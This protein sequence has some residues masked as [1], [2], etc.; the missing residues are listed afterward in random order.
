MPGQVWFYYNSNATKDLEKKKELG[1]CTSR[2][3]VIIQAAFYPEWNDIVTVCPMTSSDRRSGVYIDST[4]L[5]DGSMIEGGT[6][7]PYLFYNIRTKYLF[8]M[9]SSSHKR[10]LL[11]LSEEDFAKVKHGFYYHLG[12]TSEPPEY[13]EKWKHLPDYDRSIIVKDVKLAIDEYE[14]AFYGDHSGNY[15]PHHSNNPVLVQSH[16]VCEMVENHAVAADTHFD[17]S[18]HQFSSDEEVFNS[19]RLG[20]ETPKPVKPSDVKVSYAKMQTH[21]FAN[22]LSMLTGEY[23]P[24]QSDDPLYTKDKP[25]DNME[26]KTIIT[27]YNENELMGLLNAPLQELLDLGINSKSTASRFRKALRDLEWKCGH[28]DSEQNC[29]IFDQDDAPEP[30][31]YTGDI[32]VNKNQVKKS[33]KR[34]KLL[35]SI[36]ME[37]RH[38]LLNTPFNIISEKYHIN[39]TVVRKLIEDIRQVEAQLDTA[40][41]DGKIIPE[42]YHEDKKQD[43]EVISDTSS[44]SPVVEEADIPPIRPT[45]KY[46]ETLCPSEANE[47]MHCRAKNYKNMCSNFHITRGKAKSL[48]GQVANLVSGSFKQPCISSYVILS[49]AVR[50]I[51]LDHMN[52]ANLYEML[53]F[54]QTDPNIILSVIPNSGNTP[55]KASIRHIK[56]QVRRLIVND[57]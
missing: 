12:I 21:I 8:P 53:A 30:F 46:W 32:P 54:C 6:V 20:E 26:L 4:V 33:L 50:K 34:R 52:N 18:T 35:F 17:H 23:Y 51:L 43:D 45:Y 37:E 24:L 56:Y 57:F 31:T 55:S 27:E 13:V 11:S 5:K 10:K 2:P 44:A 3:V 42:E 29:F 15:L 9:I 39:T 47:I 25:L 19:L 48:K 36:P 49:E 38:A 1:S 28:Y 22:T 40:R 16:K 14:D 7:L 41:K